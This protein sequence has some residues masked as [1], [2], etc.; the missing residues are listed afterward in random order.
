MK[1]VKPLTDYVMYLYENKKGCGA[2]KKKG[3]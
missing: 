1:K 3:N 2:E